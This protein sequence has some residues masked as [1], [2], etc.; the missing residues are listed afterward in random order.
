MRQTVD[1]FLSLYSK[2]LLP[3][4]SL[5]EAALQAGLLDTTSVTG[6][7]YLEGNNVGA[8]YATD[9][10]QASTR[11]N[12]AQDLSQIH[13]LEA[14]VCMAAEGGARSVQGGNWRIFAGMIKVSEAHLKLETT[15]ESI[16]R[17]KHNG[18]FTLRT[19]TSREDLHF[20]AVVLAAPWGQADLAITPAPASLPDKVDYVS[21]H[22]T[23]FA[24]PY[25]LRP[26]YFHLPAAEGAPKAILT[27]HADK[28]TK[29]PFFSISL[30]RAINNYHV[31]PA[32]VEYAYKIFSPTPLNDTFLLD[33]LDLPPGSPLGEEAKKAAITWSHR[34]VWDAYPYLTPRTSFD[35]P[36]MRFPN[37]EGGL[38][39]T[40]GMESFIS[41]METSALMGKNVGKLLADRFEL[42]EKSDG[43]PEL[44]VQDGQRGWGETDVTRLEI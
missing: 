30:L 14:M 42:E 15:V 8:S 29:L 38:Y 17:R 2:P 40:S 16:T 28:G 39:Y 43:K 1:K 36:E 4:A 12:Y 24:S 9:I 44:R 37:E 7:E 33:L 6:A 21:Q 19:N 31:S 34:K 13:A 25:R 32:R 10:V 35:G 22:V 23:L 20:D 5:T 18:G 41:T 3:F 27:T 26:S 11:V